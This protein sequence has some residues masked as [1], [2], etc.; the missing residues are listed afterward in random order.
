MIQTKLRYAA[1]LQPE[2]AKDL[3]CLTLHQSLGSVD[4]LAPLSPS[5]SPLCP[6]SPYRV[7]AQRWLTPFRLD[8]ANREPLL[9]AILVY[10][11]I[12]LTGITG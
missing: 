3:L 6:E 7:A 12:V 2:G 10:S 9:F 5:L 8:L 11:S 4:A 1:C